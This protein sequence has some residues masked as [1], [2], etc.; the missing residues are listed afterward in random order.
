MTDLKIKNRSGISRRAVV[1]K[2]EVA[3]ELVKRDLNLISDY[4]VDQNFID[5]F[6]SKVNNLK[7]LPAYGK[8][9]ALSN[10]VSREK[11][12]A[13]LVLTKELQKSKRKF[14]MVFPIG[15]DIYNDFMRGDLAGVKINDFAKLAVNMID[16]LEEHIEALTGV[17]ITE[18][19]IT[20]LRNKV[21]DFDSKYVTKEVDN[22]TADTPTQVRNKA[23]NDVYSDLVLI[24]KAGKALWIDE[25]SPA[26]YN[27]YLLTR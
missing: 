7:S 18:E 10:A 8:L 27:D 4:G 15:S 20:Q 9:K 19:T 14:A 5:G 2:S 22:K 3:I 12:D 26:N 11:K 17:G 25:E 16:G 13:K 21:A 23:I 24:C 1:V 6:E